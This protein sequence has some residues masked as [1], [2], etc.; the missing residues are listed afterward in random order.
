LVLIKDGKDYRLGRPELCPNKLNELVER[1]KSLTV[2]GCNA[3]LVCVGGE[4]II[5]D[6]RLQGNLLGS[7]CFSLADFAAA[8]L[9]FSFKNFFF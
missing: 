3:P 6:F 8:V 1:E 5:C 7:S 9:F 2:K 4:I